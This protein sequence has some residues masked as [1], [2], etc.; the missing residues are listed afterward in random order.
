[1]VEENMARMNGNMERF[2]V[3]GRN[4]L[5]QALQPSNSQPLNGSSSQPQTSSNTPPFSQHASQQQTSNLQNPYG[6]GHATQ[7]SASFVPSLNPS[8]PLFA[9]QPSQPPEPYSDFDYIDPTTFEF[10]GNN[11]S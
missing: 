2:E 9:P 6:Q 3:I 5:K 4:F 8:Q 7:P 10:L 1:M 11:T